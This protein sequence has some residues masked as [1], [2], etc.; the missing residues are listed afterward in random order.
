M[1]NTD[2]EQERLVDPERLYVESLSRFTTGLGQAI[3]TSSSI[4]VTF[5]A[6]STSGLGLMSRPFT[7]IY[8]PN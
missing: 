5:L 8:V 6:A 4:E 1:A 7:G 3:G 2:E